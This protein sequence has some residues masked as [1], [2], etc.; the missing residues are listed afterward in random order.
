MVGAVPRYWRVSPH[1]R[2]DAVL[3]EAGP[4]FGGVLFW[5]LGVAADFGTMLFGTMLFGTMLLPS[6][7][8][9]KAVSM[10][11]VALSVLFSDLRS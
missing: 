7:A 6:D 9:G 11:F 1:S 3:I 8:E 10:I 4:R 5:E 2:G